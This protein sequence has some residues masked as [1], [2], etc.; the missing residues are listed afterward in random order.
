MVEY[1]LSSSFIVTATTTGKER[2][3]PDQEETRS[4]PT[5]GGPASPQNNGTTALSST[6]SLSPPLAEGRAPALQ[7]LRRFLSALHHFAA[8]VSAESGERVKQ[9]IHNLVAGT[10]NIEE[11]Q[12]GVQESTN[13]PLRASVPGFLRALLPLAQRDLH[14]RARKAKQTPLQF[15]RAHEHLILESGGDG[16]D[17]FAPQPSGSV[18]PGAKRRASDP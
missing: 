10:V 18:E 14:S 17:I 15:V 13:Y 7:R 6:E 3:S 11:F 12:T 4:S 5:P 8:D 16:G 2:R 9:L 1:F